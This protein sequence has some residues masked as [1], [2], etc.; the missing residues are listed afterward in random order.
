MLPPGTRQ[1][2]AQASDVGIPP[3]M[4]IGINDHVPCGCVLLTDQRLDHACCPSYFVDNLLDGSIWRRYEGV[5]KASLGKGLMWSC[6][7]EARISPDITS[8]NRRQR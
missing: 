6:G 1:V 3:G 8:L 7:A 5:S 4:N 2:F